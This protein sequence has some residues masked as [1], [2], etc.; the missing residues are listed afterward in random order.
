LLWPRRA[1]AVLADAE[2][3]L[4]PGHDRE[5]LAVHPVPSAR[6]VTI[7]LAAM[8]TVGWGELNMLGLKT[9]KRQA[10]SA[11]EGY[12]TCL[13]AVNRIKS[14]SD[15]LF[16]N[17]QAATKHE[18]PLRPD[19][20]VRTGLKK[21]ATQPTL[22][23][24][25]F[26]DFECPSCKRFATFVEDQAQPLFAGHIKTVFKHY[27]LDRTC[28]E[29]VSKTVHPHACAAMSMAEAAR[30]LGGNSAFWQAHDYLYKLR[31]T[32]AQG[33]LTPDAVASELHLDPAAFREAGSSQAA[34]TRVAEDI[35]QAKRCDIRGTP[36]VFVEG[37][38]VDSLAVTEIGFWDKLADV[39]WQRLQLSRPAST[40]PKPSP[41]T[42]GTPDRKDAP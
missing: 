32:L 33:K 36:A 2:A 16:R 11:T 8:V 21:D 37:R 41:T 10:A 19:D 14:D 18:I 40:K 1:K 31:D 28:N 26:S 42:P 4:S 15:V 13:E 27:P 30:M 39:Y 6:T 12:K 22:D 7:T 34:A 29:R 17:W 38:L 9:W 23:V 25:V 3:G 35:N 5:S 24:V 20:P